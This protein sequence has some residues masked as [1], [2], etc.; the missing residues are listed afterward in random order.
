M[1]STADEYFAHWDQQLKTVSGELAAAGQERRAASQASFAKLEK[2]VAALRAVYAPFMDELEATDRFLK[3]DPTAS[4]VKAAAP[5]L[6]KVLD[7]EE[8]VLEHA[9]A[10]IAEIDAVHGGC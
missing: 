4:G 3:A 6:R 1:K 9:D 10:V 5:S 2:S 7:K 8:D